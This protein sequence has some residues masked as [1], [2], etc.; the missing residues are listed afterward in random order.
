MRP[1]KKI[2]FIW[3]IRE[4][5]LIKDI[6]D[7]HL[8]SSNLITASTQQKSDMQNPGTVLKEEVMNL[9]IHLT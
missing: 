7:I 3:S 9:K 1:I 5:L 6:L 4:V 8:S 2:T